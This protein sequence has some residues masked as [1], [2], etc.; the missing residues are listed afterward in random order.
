MGIFRSLTRSQKETIG[1]LQIGTFLEYFDLMLYVHMAVI[2][3]ELFFPKTDAHTAALVSAFAFCST[4]I[5][6]PFGAILFGWIGDN[7]GRKTT[8]IITTML[9]AVS[10]M[11]MANLPTYAQIGIT[12]AW[13][14]T[15]CRVLQGISAMGEIIGAQ[16]YLM[17]ITKPP[18]RYPVVSLMQVFSTLGGFAALAIATLCTVSQFNWRL[19]FWIGACVAVVGS[20]ARTRL[21]E[22][23]DFLKEQEKKKAKTYQPTKVTKKNILAYF[24]IQCGWPVCF[25]F[26]Y[27]YCGDLLK[28]LFG[29]SA[30]QVI[31][32]NLRV[33]FI[34]IIGAIAFVAASVWIHPLKILKA[35]FWIFVPFILICPYLMFDLQSVNILFFI[36]CFTLF[37]GLGVLPAD[38]VF[39]SHF[40][41]NKRFTSI[42]LIYSISRAFMYVITSFGLVYAVEYWGF[43]GI[44]IIMIPLCAG[45]CW[46]VYHFEKLE[47]EKGTYCSYDALIKTQKATLTGSSV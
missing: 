36:Q 23:P 30:D 8:V 20:I 27:V 7:V 10:C 39:F 40:P 41:V 32:N 9:M 16:I 31:H 37:F 2:L 29:Y 14:L 22:T 43:G 13:L 26:S 44:L 34:Q 33:S 11:I 6:R 47:R 28:K 18:A 25:Y 17:E 46:S 19:A 12:A 38:A 42:S 45:Y 21:R 24:F 15:L 1:L 35:A 3:N 4:F 5:L